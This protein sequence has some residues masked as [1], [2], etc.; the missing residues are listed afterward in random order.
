[1]AD[2]ITDAVAQG[3]AGLNGYL[4]SEWEDAENDSLRAT[5][6]GHAAEI[7]RMYRALWDTYDEQG[8][9]LVLQSW[10]H[11]AEGLAGGVMG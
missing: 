5:Y 4:E 2:A 3:L 11:K 10:A 6:E 9:F 7:V 1:M 8:V